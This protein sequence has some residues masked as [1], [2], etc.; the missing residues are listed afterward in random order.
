M[1]ITW[2]SYF[3]KCGLLKC[4]ASEVCIVTCL[5]NYKTENRG[6]LQNYNEGSEYGPKCHWLGTVS[7]NP[8]QTTLFE[9]F[10]VHGKY[11]LWQKRHLKT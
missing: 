2:S 8:D 7:N 3:K 5:V 9:R 4:T 11:F 6:I 1:Y 10:M